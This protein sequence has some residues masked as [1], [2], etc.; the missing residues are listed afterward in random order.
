MAINKIEY[1]QKMQKK[2]DQNAVIKSVSGWMDANAGEVVYT[3]GNE[4][5]IPTMSTSGMQQK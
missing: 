4:I 2:L 3:G 5:K 1:G